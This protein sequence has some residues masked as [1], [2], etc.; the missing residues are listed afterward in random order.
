M[1][2]K[3]KQDCKIV[4]NGKTMRKMKRDRFRHKKVGY[5]FVIEKIDPLSVEY[6][7]VL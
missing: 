5:I 2:I 3:L 7:L 4:W 6:V 1:R